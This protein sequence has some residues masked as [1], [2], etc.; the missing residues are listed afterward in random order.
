MTIPYGLPVTLGDGTKGHTKLRERAFVSRVS[1][2]KFSWLDGKGRICTVDAI[3]LF[4]NA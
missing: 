1:A 2:G 3:I 4:T